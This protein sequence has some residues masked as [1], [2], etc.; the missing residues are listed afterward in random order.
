[1]SDQLPG[2][3]WKSSDLGNCRCPICGDSKKDKSK[4]RF[5]F[6]ADKGSYFVKC[7]NC[8]YTTAFSKFLQDSNDNLYREYLFERFSNNRNKIQTATKL[9]E[10]NL[11]FATDNSKLKNRCL[12]GLPSI[13]KLPE[14]HYA[15]EYI[16]TRKIPEKYYSILYYA[17]DFSLVAKELDPDKKV[18][19]EPRLIIPMFDSTGHVLAVQG[20][21]FDKTDALRYI[22]IKDQNYTGPKVFG[23]DRYNPM[24]KGYMVEGPIDSL[25]LPNAIASAG[26]DLDAKHD[27]N[28]NVENIT[29]VFDN[30]PRNPEICALMNKCIE[31]GYSV[32]I[33]PKDLNKKDINDMVLVG[34]NPH[35]IIDSNTYKGLSAKIRFYEWKKV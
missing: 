26:S 25:F 32:C 20:R 4:K 2:F 21:S 31:K 6:F 33:W 34:L 22:T 28:I 10:Q 9:E 17:E 35:I 15:K 16:K 7:H 30:E 19:S 1:M 18:R 3:V 5:Y 14:T 11:A 12:I 13:D 27:T 29:F 24:I 8:Q 23:L